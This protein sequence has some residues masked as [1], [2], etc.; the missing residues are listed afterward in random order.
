MPP[1]SDII[2][3][4]T[5]FCFFCLLLLFVCLVG[6]IEKWFLQIMLMVSTQHLTHMS[7]WHSPLVGKGTGLSQS[8]KFYC[9]IHVIAYAFKTI[10][11]PETVRDYGYKKFVRPIPAF[12][13]SQSNGRKRCLSTSLQSLHWGWNE[14]CNQFHYRL[15][16]TWN[17]PYF[18]TEIVLAFYGLL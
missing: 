14:R 10:F 3:C 2:S 5:F 12:R 15:N 4:W 7:K 8:T 16:L 13:K 1:D 18:F 6:L 11:V 9:Y 17:Q